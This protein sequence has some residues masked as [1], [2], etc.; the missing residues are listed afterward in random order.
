MKHVLLICAAAAAA[1]LVPAHAGASGEAAPEEACETGATVEVDIAQFA[2]R[3]KRVT[4]QRGDVVLWTNRDAAPHTATE[5]GLPQPVPD[6]H[7]SVTSVAESVH[8]F[9]S[10]LLRRDL[11][12]VGPLVTPRWDSGVLGRDDAFA[13]DACETGVFEYQCD[14]HLFH[15]TLEVVP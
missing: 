7:P 2:F 3:P 9:A 8:G 12:G 13:Y 11:P 15:G 5:T 14:L 6:A 1:L 4:V 10:L